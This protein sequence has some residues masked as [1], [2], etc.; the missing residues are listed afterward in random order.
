MT[1]PIV[2]L[3]AWNLRAQ[4]QLGQNFL[5]DPSTAAM[6]V[7]NA[8]ISSGDILFEIGAGLGALT[9][10]MAGAAEKV[11]AVETDRNLIR[12][13]K[14]ELLAGDISNVVLINE[15]ILQF[16]IKRLAEQIDQKLLVVGNLPYKIS[17]QIIV[18]LINSRDRLT[19][20]VLMLQKE[21]ACRLTAKPGCRDYGR[22]TVMLQY[23]SN[24]R[25]IADIRAHLFFPEPKI[26]SR[27][28]ELT[29]KNT[30]EYGV[31]D[32][33]IL[34][35]VIKA[36]FSKRRKTLRNSLS[37]NLLNLDTKTSARVLDAAEID[38][39]R[40]AETLSVQEFVRL[41][42]SFKSVQL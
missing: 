35:M 19:R 1:S 23:C 36:A 40:R 29:F 16:D 31:H 18:Q 28:I 6:I 14:T 12:L 22:L 30:H 8:K 20:A 38:Q 10:P 27:V 9:I 42:N 4:K 5:T 39:S 37:G 34:F 2:L 25:K 7:K 41:S 21:M 11:Y 33:K 32:E 15:N 13:L 3:K 26:D 24:I 17:S